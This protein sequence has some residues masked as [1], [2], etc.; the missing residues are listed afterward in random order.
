MILC[1][2][3]GTVTA[4]FKHPAFSG[5]RLMVVQPVDERDGTIGASFIA[6]DHICSAGPGDL[7]LVLREGNGVRQIVKDKSAPIRSA[8]VG[9]VD[10]VSS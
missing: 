5:R 3:L 10:Q 1:R 8:I 6:I 9:W 7:V 2:V 4:T